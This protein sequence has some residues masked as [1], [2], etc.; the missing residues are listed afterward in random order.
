MAVSLADLSMARQEER[1]AIWTAMASA[2]PVFEI[3][4]GTW[5]V[6]ETL[7]SSSESPTCADAGAEPVKS[8]VVS[9][10]S[11]TPPNASAGR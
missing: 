2:G 8:T 10:G 4:G 7:S 6:T 9:N 5:M 11:E 3:P 1:T